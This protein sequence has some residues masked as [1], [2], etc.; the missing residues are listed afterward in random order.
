MDPEKLYRATLKITFKILHNS[1]IPMFNHIFFLSCKYI[2]AIFSLACF[3]G[4]AQ[5]MQAFLYFLSFFSCVRAPKR[6]SK[7][8]VFVAETVETGDKYLGVTKAMQ[9]RLINNV[10]LRILL[11]WNRWMLDQCLEKRRK[12]F[13]W[14]GYVNFHFME[15]FLVMIMRFIFGDDWNDTLCWSRF[16]ENDLK[17]L[18]DCR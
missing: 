3:S 5:K 6:G 4:E 11:F 2:D 8:H 12:Q 17:R 15:F 9:G 10:G 14:W 16:A 18:F 13:R 1:R 7:S